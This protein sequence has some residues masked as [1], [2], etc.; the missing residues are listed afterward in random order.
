MEYHNRLYSGEGPRHFARP[1]VVAFRHHLVRR[2]VQA[3]GLT[4]SSRVLS[5]GCGLGD[6]ELLLA[7]HVGHL[8]GIDIADAGIGAAREAAQRQGA[9]NAAFALARLEDLP[10]EP[11]Y[12]AV[13][14]IFFLHHLPDDV[15]A[16]TPARIGRLLR[17]G[18]RVYAL[19]PSIDRLSGKVGQI[20]FPRLMAKYQTEDER[21]L[22]LSHVES[23]FREAGFQVAGGYYDFGSTPLAGL[24]PG[25]AAGYRLARRVDNLL[26]KS[27]TLR[28]WGS[29]FELVA[30]RP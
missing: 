1:A 26:L 9:D 22:A 16:A 24:L 6:T 10:P 11:A 28:R 8:T 4:R 13:L 19:D 20:L 21:E 18:G 30:T 2:I 27:A 12:D 14:A 25:W 5:V 17:P 15:L 7:P 23:L 3:C 29:N